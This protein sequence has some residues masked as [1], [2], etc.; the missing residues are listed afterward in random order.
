MGCYEAASMVT[1]AL[2]MLN[3]NENTKCKHIPPPDTQREFPFAFFSS[4]HLPVPPLFAV[5]RVTKQLMLLEEAKQRLEE[6]LVKSREESKTN[7]KEVQVLQT[8]L[9]DA[10]TQEE[11]CSITEN[12]RRCHYLFYFI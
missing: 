11:H 2:E 10:V 3:K 12:L 6:E 9:R 8:R 5:T 4:V 7:V 1:A